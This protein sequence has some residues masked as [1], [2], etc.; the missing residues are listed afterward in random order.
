MKM[1]IDKNIIENIKSSIIVVLMISTILL[2]YFFWGKLSLEDIK[3]PTSQN[4]YEIMD[5][6]D[7][8]VP[9]QIIISLGEDSYKLAEISKWDEMAQALDEFMQSD[10]LL[11]E[12]ITKEQYN[13]VMNDSSI[14]A[15]FDYQ[16]SLNE[17]CA[18]SEIKTSPS[19]DGIETM[20]EIGYGRISEESLLIYDSKKTKYFRIIFSNSANLLGSLLDSQLE[21][22][23]PVYFTLGKYLGG[24]VSNETIIPIT[25]QT[26]LNKFDYNR[27]IYSKKNDDV[28]TLAQSYF[29]KNFDFIRKI[30]EGNGTVIYMYGYG[31]KVLIVNTN[32]IVEYKEESIGI[33]NEVGY[34]DS[35]KTALNFILTHGGFEGS[36][37]SKYKPFLKNVEISMDGNGKYTF[38]F[39]LEVNGNR[40]YYQDMDPIKIEITKNQVTYFKRD[41]S[42]YNVEQV[43]TN[44]DQYKE[45]YSAINMLAENYKYFVN[46]MGM[47]GT[48]E[49]IAN[50]IISLKYGYAV[51]RKND[52][53]QG[54]A[55]P[56]WIVGFDGMEAYFD[57]YSIE[58]LGFKMTK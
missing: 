16:M 56:A 4:N 29:G 42:E 39:G 36:T 2:L 17:F 7:L 33:N 49:E 41:L 51:V 12:E 50:R 48:F 15:K 38:T 55:R 44:I 10:P 19:Y 35:L 32:G 13:K 27:E 3:L 57:L 30:E 11:V 37:G 28:S 43:E 8:L 23:S 34:L 18:A 25:F 53:I 45:A 14:R 20:S 24:N 5:V 1:A 40:V 52:Q 54:T 22:D 21:E 47:I 26:N 58:P 6:K 46:E 31:Q 9:S